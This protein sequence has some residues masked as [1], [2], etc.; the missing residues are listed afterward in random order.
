MTRRTWLLAVLAAGLQV[1]CVGDRTLPRADLVEDLERLV[2]ILEDAHPDPYARGGGKG[3]FD[4]RLAELIEGLPAGG[5]T[6]NAFGR[7][8]M[9]FMAALGD[10]HTHLYVDFDVNWPKPGGIPLFFGVVGQELYVLG[11]LD[12]REKRLTGARLRAVAGVPFAEI[13]RRVFRM[14]PCENE[15]E[16]LAYLAWVGDLWTEPQLAMLVPEW[17]DHSRLAVEL[18]LADDTEETVVFELPRALDYRVDV[19]DSRVTLPPV[20]RAEFAHAFLDSTQ[21]TAILRVVG[22]MHYREALEMWDAM[23]VDQRQSTGR[24]AYEQYH[25]SDPPEDYQQV[26]AGVPSAT[27]TFRSLVTEMRAAGTKTLLVDLRRNSG[28]NSF[29][30]NILVYFL[31][32]KETLLGRPPKLEV[33][34]YSQYYFEYFANESIET[35]NEGR[36]VPLAVGE[37]DT[38]SNPRLGVSEDLRSDRIETLRLMRSF[39]PELDSGAYS[40]YYRPEHVI[41]LVSPKTFSSGFTMM[42][43]LWRAGAKLLGTPS[44]QAANCYGD[45]LEFELP[46]SGVR[47]CVSHKQFIEFPE[48]PERGRVLPVDYPMT[49]ER[50]RSYGFDPN[51]EV[52]YALEIVEP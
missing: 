11:V 13:R 16:A 14:H 7:Y 2:W 15:Y 4:A 9:P 30:S 38:I 40:G 44:G 35:V 51:A 10:G 26:I 19:P 33:K 21:Q 47:G 8:L 32:G 28:G 20:E 1:G 39:A 42:R 46:H 52:L 6:A 12:E 34:K 45:I 43:Y 25:G 27:E 5:M 24:E 31:Y 18:A 50:L 37:C 41:V 23:G 48:D 29:M 3:A 17:E 36:A 49:Y 22:M